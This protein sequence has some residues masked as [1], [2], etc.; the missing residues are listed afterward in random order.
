MPLPG[1]SCN[2]FR[3]TLPWSFPYLRAEM[4]I[5]SVKCDGVAVSL[6]SWKTAWSVAPCQPE[7][8]QTVCEE[9]ISVN[10]IWTLT[11]G[12]WYIFVILAHPNIQSYTS[13]VL[14]HVI[15]RSTRYK[16]SIVMMS[17][18][19]QQ[20]KLLSNIK[21]SNSYKLYSS[22]NSV[23][24]FSLKFI[25]IIHLIFRFSDSQQ[26][27]LFCLQVLSSSS[28][29][30]IIVRQYFDYILLIKMFYF[31]FSSNGSSQL[32]IIS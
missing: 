3:G 19:G 29:I 21:T 2:N 20:H 7:M 31:Y 25:L 15:Q 13:L 4:V 23:L 10:S 16:C 18:S 8:L 14:Y 22:L 11:L 6:G 24:N 17:Y 26:N 1:L 30:P 12:D 32:K 28:Y 9:K 5:T 27:C